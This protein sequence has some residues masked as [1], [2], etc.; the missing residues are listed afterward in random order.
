MKKSNKGQRNAIILFAL[1]LLAGA[2][3]YYPRIVVTKPST[4]LDT[5]EHYTSY[6]SISAHRKKITLPDGSTAILNSS[7]RLYVPNSFSQSHREVILNGE[8]YFDVKQDTQHPFIVKTDKLTATVLGTCFKMRSLETQNGATLYVMSGKVKV[9][10]SYHSDTD[11]QPETLECG[12]M[13]MANK[14]IDL[15]EKET[16]EVNDLENWLQEKVEFK[17]TTLP[18]ALRKIED[19]YGIETEIKGSY[20]P[21]TLV[22]A[23]FKNASL[24]QVLDALGEKL[25]F[26]Y[27]VKG[28]K[29]ILKF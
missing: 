9:A 28:N 26:D 6:E 25:K 13:V 24:E 8:A 7:S 11:N 5:A 23:S 3:I 22:S 15:M 16:F 14:Q 29:V 17:E 21:S 27:K 18:L 12:Q 2:A 1:I 20:D 4:L 10:K 19:W